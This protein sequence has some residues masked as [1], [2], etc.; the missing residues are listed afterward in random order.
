MC[1]RTFLPK[2]GLLVAEASAASSDEV[3]GR[4]KPTLNVPAGTVIFDFLLVSE[5]QEVEIAEVF[6]QEQWGNHDTLLSLVAIFSVIVPLQC[7]DS[8]DT[9]NI[10]SF[11]GL[12]RPSP[13][14]FLLSWFH[15]EGLSELK[16]SCR[17]AAPAR[18]TLVPTQGHSSEPT[19]ACLGRL[20]VGKT[21]LG[22][23]GDRLG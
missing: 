17:R 13:F 19:K 18:W 14:H 9:S 5:S 22:G 2:N 20:V 4:Y 15:D 16:L 23:R 21:R 11:L 3:G 10:M 6:L 12:I 7:Q 8:P 1:P